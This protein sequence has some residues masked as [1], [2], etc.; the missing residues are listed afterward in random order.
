MQTVVYVFAAVGALCVAYSLS[1]VLYM[2][3]LDRGLPRLRG[4]APEP[5]AYPAL[6]AVTTPPTSAA[7][8]TVASFSSRGEP[9]PQSAAVATQPMRPRPSSGI[10]LTGSG[11][12]VTASTA[13]GLRH[14]ARAASGD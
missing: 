2:L 13:T 7:L 9:G 12:D 8:N 11:F 5:P 4:G 10:A 3:A 1:L 14:L 6:R